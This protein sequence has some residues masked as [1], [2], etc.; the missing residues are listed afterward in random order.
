MDRDTT[1]GIILVS[2]A[3]VLLN[4]LVFWSKRRIDQIA[5]RNLHSVREILKELDSGR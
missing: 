3:I 2:G 5:A 1:L 4:Y